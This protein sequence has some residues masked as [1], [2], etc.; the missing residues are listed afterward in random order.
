MPRIRLLKCLFWLHCVVRRNIWEALYESHSIQQFVITD[1]F[2]TAVTKNYGFDYPKLDCLAPRLL[3]WRKILENKMQSEPFQVENTYSVNSQCK[4]MN[5]QTIYC[6]FLA[7]LKSCHRW[8]KLRN[9]SKLRAAIG[10]RA[11]LGNFLFT[12]KFKFCYCDLWRKYIDF[13]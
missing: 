2:G 9:R 3:K 4:H 8:R 1:W 5:W 11:A 13:S 6:C 7:Y 12:S 10:L